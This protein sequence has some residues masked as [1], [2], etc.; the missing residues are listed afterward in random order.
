M[1]YKNINSTG[2]ALHTE[3]EQGPYIK[4]ERVESVS[5]DTPASNVLKDEGGPCE[6]RSGRRSKPLLT[7]VDGT[8]FKILPHKSTHKNLVVLCKKCECEVKGSR[9]S[10]TN[11]V[12]HLKRK[13]GKE[14]LNEYE[15]YKKSK[16][17][18]HVR[19]RSQENSNFTQ[20]QFEGLFSRFVVNAMVPFRVVEDKYL[21]ELFQTLNTDKYGLKVPSTYAVAKYTERMFESTKKTLKKLLSNVDY[22]CITADILSGKRR[23]FFMVTAHWITETFERKSA[24]LACR[25]FRRPH[26]YERIAHKLLGIQ[27]DFGLSSIKIAATVMENGS[28]FFKTFRSFG[29]DR[30]LIEKH[31]SNVFVDDDEIDVQFDREESSSDSE[32][33]ADAP[34]PNPGTESA[35]SNFQSS[36]TQFSCFSHTLNLCCSTDLEA[37]IHQ[38]T[39]F[40]TTHKSVM[41]KCNALWTLAT[42]PETSKILGDALGHTLS[43]PKETSWNSLYDSLRQI[44]KAESRISQVYRFTNTD[45]PLQLTDSDFTYIR[46]YVECSAP[47][48]ELLDILHGEEDVYFGIV[49]PS[50]SS[51]KYKLQQLQQ[52]QWIY[53][54][55]VIDCY[56]NSVQNRFAEFFNISTP[57]AET[58]TI[59]AF[60]NPHF[61]KRWLKCLDSFHHARLLQLFTNAV[62]EC[63]RIK[64][65]GTSSK[66]AA[67]GLAPK[68]RQFFDFG[69]EED[70]NPNSESNSLAQMQ[71][72][73][74]FVNQSLS[75]NVLNDYPAIKEV[76]FKT[77]TILPSSAPVERLFSFVSITNAPE[78]NRLSDET[79][80]MRV[81]LKANNYQFITN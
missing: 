16:S 47:L 35:A 59:A 13:H 22:V 37:V 1:E 48:A 42:S 67:E 8:F 14:A 18:Q 19:V 26:T 54:Q 58:A 12:L 74:Y 78:A 60:A 65:E 44:L 36:P 46:E 61:K 34:Q 6:T 76:F 31:S 28:N 2:S 72:C 66:A 49:M 17:Q 15:L 3:F 39:E 20:R 4:I 25:R 50:L 30:A 69:K 24:A 51:L 75:F 71:I 43:R 53:C 7:I 5:W 27:Q 57:L 21:R 23:S 45:Q 64:L 33:F 70:T 32:S 40:A 80:E 38:Q 63:V 68:Y 9:F 73:S 79:F 52:K 62:S 81:V 29:V 77:N 11:F 56:L 10:T 41:G 55:P